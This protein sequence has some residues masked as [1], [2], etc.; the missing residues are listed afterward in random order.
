MG[1]AKVEKRWQTKRSTV[2]ERS[3]YMFNNPLLSDVKFAFPNTE[4]TIPAHKYVLAVSSPVFL[5][6][7]FGDLAES[8]DAIDITEC[9]PDIFL[10]FL[11]FIY[12]D[13]ANFEGIDCAVKLWHLADEYDVP[14]LAK[15]CEEFL[16]GN[17]REWIRWTFSKFFDIPST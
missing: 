16:N 17:I 11:R 12:C 5:A 6:V 15:E 13:E 4:T 3:K 14:S 10:R 1:S 7:F 2:L 8:S 9:D